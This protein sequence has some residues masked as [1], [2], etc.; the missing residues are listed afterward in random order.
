[1]SCSI[2]RIVD[3]VATDVVEQPLQRLRLGRVHA[4]GGLVEREQL[5]LGRER[6]GDL[7]PPLVAVG[8]MLGEIVG[9]LGDADVLE[10]LVGRAS[11]SPPP[12]PACP[13][14]A[15]SR[16]RH[17]GLRAHVAAD[18]HVLQ[19]RQV[20]R[21]GRMFWNVRAMPRSATSL[22]FSRS[23]GSPSKVNVAAVRL[24]D[25][26]QHVEQ[27]RLAGAVRARSGRRSR[28]G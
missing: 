2:S 15:R 6:A 13:R 25:A 1:M 4:G 21:T 18:H 19:R 20:L 22:G 7:E 8:E 10:Q 28:R 23:S 14:R 16:R 12:R 3:A 27:R 24:I 26:G 17:A 9:A 11:R 5:G